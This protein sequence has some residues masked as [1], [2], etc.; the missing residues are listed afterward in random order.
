MF[1]KLKRLFSFFSV[2]TI[3]TLAAVPIFAILGGCSNP[4]EAP[5]D[6]SEIVLLTPQGGETF[7]VG[8][9]LKVRWKLQGNASIDIIAVDIELSPDN[10][11]TWGPLNVS[12]VY[13]TDAQWA[14]FSWKIPGT[15]NFRGDTYTLENNSQC[16]LHVMQYS[17]LN[18][19]LISTTKTAFTIL[20]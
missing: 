3:I 9:S 13:P 10:G 19:N 5:V 1:S 18:P 12:S 4:E 6:N 20:P 11:K 15:I 2:S 17:T 16:L 14:N 7:H 8:D